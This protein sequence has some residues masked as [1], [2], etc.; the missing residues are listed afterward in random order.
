MRKIVLARSAVAVVGFALPVASPA[1][2]EDKTVVV[3]KKGH[4]GD[5]QHHKTVVVKPDQKP[6]VK[7][8]IK[9]NRD[10]GD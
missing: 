4:D 7:G 1:N 6:A 5:A 3:K 8:D 2:A 10:V 9:T